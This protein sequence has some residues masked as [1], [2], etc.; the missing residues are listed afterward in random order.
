M[1]DSIELISIAGFPKYLLNPQTL[2]ILSFH[3]SRN[4]KLRAPN[5]NDKGS[6]GYRL[7]NNGK[8][9]FFSLEE[10]KGTVE[11]HKIKCSLKEEKKMSQAN[12]GVPV[13]GNFIVGSLSKVN[14]ALSFS[15]FPSRHTTWTAANN[16]AARLAQSV[17]DKKFIVVEVKGIVSV[18]DVVWE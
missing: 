10:L 15:A 12:T 2:E 9:R 1:G 18:S 3:Y 16:E 7:Y 11:L 13:K 6:K 14:G 5:W 4:G 8:T 17:K